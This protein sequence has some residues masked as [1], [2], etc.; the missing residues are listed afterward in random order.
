M[1]VSQ[2]LRVLFLVIVA[3]ATSAGCISHQ[4][5]TSDI[6]LATPIPA[7]TSPTVTPATV[8]AN[9]SD[10][11]RVVGDVTFLTPVPDSPASIPAYRGI[12]RSE[13]QIDYAGDGVL[14][15]RNYVISKEDALNATTHALE[16]YGGIPPDAIFDGIG[17]TYEKTYDYTTGKYLDE[18]PIVISVGFIRKIGGKP[19]VGTPDI[20]HLDFGETKE[21]V[22][23]YK[24]WRTIEPL[25]YNISV[26]SVDEALEHLENFDTMNKA[27]TMPYSDNETD[28]FPN[29]TVRAMSLG[30]YEGSDSEIIFEPVWIIEGNYANGEKFYNYVDARQSANFTSSPTFVLPS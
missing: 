3:F 16:K 1:S 10:L 17:Y 2:P 27:Q 8:P 4:I 24:R 6:P 26:I 5:A 22:T 19:I 20:I 12:L 14:K 28:Y 7:M 18:K 9:Q 11:P 30:Y 13:D 25:G 29:A 23:I 15:P 21:P